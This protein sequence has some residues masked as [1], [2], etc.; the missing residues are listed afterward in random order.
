VYALGCSIIGSTIT[1][2]AGTSTGIAFMLGTI[3]G[4]TWMLII[5]RERAERAA[6]KAAPDAYLAQPKKP[7]PGLDAMINT[8]YRE[9]RMD[10]DRPSAPW[11]TNPKT[12]PGYSRVS[13]EVLKDM[14]FWDDRT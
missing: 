13:R 6:A 1:L 10:E 4:L 9:Q 3:A 2:T 14:G 7:W 8:G 12:P 5:A 11:P